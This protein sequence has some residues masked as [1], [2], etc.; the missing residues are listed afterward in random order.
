MPMPDNIHNWLKLWKQ[1]VKAILPNYQ[2]PSDNPQP[3]E[4]KP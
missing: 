2:P 3:P 4:K 1:K